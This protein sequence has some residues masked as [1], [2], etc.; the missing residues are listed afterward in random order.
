M[1]RRSKDGL[2]FLKASSGCFA[3]M[4]K[5]ASVSGGRGTS[6]RLPRPT[7]VAFLTSVHRAFCDEMPDEFRRVEHPNGA[8]EPI[9][10]GRIRQEGD[11]E[12][13][14]G[15]HLPSSSGQRLGHRDR[16]LGPFGQHG[17]QGWWCFPESGVISISARDAQSSMSSGCRIAVTQATHLGTPM[18]SGAGYIIRASN[19]IRSLSCPCV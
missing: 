17:A 1:D 5:G 10:P 14:V 9:I 11:S 18:L 12:V 15:R 16:D 6:D 13:A 4:P 3:L 7:S 8:T 2:R 19:I